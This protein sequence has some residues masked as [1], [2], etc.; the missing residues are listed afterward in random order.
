VILWQDP[1]HGEWQAH[2][3]SFS[4]QKGIKTP[5]SLRNIYKELHE[6]YGY[7]RPNHGELTS[8]ADQW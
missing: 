5:P 6:E 1:Y 4:V 3:L 8:W 2:G 7:E